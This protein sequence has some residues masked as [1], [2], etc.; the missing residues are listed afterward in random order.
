MP[1]LSPAAVA[2]AVAA[3]LRGGPWSLPLAPGSIDAAQGLGDAQQ[4]QRRRRRVFDGGPPA[5]V[6]AEPPPMG[7]EPMNYGGGGDPGALA[8]PDPAYG[9]FT[10]L[11]PIDL[12]QGRPARINA[13]EDT[14]LNGHLE[15]FL[16]PVAGS[17]RES[18]TAR[19]SDF[20]GSLS[21]L[22]DEAEWAAGRVYFNPRTSSSEEIGL[23]LRGSGTSAATFSGYTFRYVTFEGAWGLSRWDAGIETV[24]DYSYSTFP[25]NYDTLALR[26]DGS[27]IIAEWVVSGDVLTVIDATYAAGWPGI[28]AMSGGGRI[29]RWG[30]TTTDV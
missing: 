3:W 17:W 29:E 27:T 5:Q 23:I 22:R 19:L 21:I 13:R 7:V 14:F 6:G 2:A 25:N 4:Q 28:I 11:M 10:V 9:P 12:W 18:S 16:R 24:L 20:S 26:A 8:T 1:E 15:G 30:W